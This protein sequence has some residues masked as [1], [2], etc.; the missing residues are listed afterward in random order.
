MNIGD[1]ILALLFWRLEL[2]P[3]S[4]QRMAAQVYT[5]HYYV[6]RTFMVDRL[7]GQN[8]LTALSHLLPLNILSLYSG[9]SVQV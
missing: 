4:W 1:K 5:T 6:I 3:H 7:A 9:G 2:D 8:T